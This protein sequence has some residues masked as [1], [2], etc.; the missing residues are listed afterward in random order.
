[1]LLE[2]VRD[3]VQAGSTFEEAAEQVRA[4]SVFTTHTPV[5]AGHDAFPLPM[6]EK[7][8]SGYW[9]E[10][11]ITRQQFMDLGRFGDSFNMTVLAL[12]MTNRRNGVSQLHGRVTRRMWQGRLAGDAPGRNPDYLRD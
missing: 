6:L 10:L 2:R 3:L 4:T 12:R 8:F 11:G 5:P 7:H 9:D 1:M